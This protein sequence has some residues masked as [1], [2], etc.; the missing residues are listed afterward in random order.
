MKK[1]KDLR[2]LALYI[3][4][5]LLKITYANHSH[6]SDCI[7][8]AFVRLGTG[9]SESVNCFSRGI[10]PRLTKRHRWL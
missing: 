1:I 4:L 6:N 5:C 7:G 9:S 3:T 2:Y 8:Y 10:P